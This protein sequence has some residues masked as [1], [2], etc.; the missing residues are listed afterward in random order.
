MM[1]TSTSANGTTSTATGTAHTDSST[2]TNSTSTRTSTST[3][4]STSASTT[5]TPTQPLAP[6]PT[7]SPSCLV[8][9]PSPFD[10]D[11]TVP[12]AIAEQLPPL[13]PGDKLL[14]LVCHEDSGSTATPQPK[15]VGIY[16]VPTHK[17]LTLDPPPDCTR[18]A[19]TVLYE[20][21]RFAQL[22]AGGNPN[23]V[24]VLYTDSGRGHVVHCCRHVDTLIGHRDA[25]VTKSVLARMAALEQQQQAYPDRVAHRQHST[26]RGGG[27]PKPP[28][29]CEE[30]KTTKV[31]PTKWPAV[32]VQTPDFNFLSDWILE[33]RL[34]LQ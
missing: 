14:C 19:S 34:K 5:C 30:T 15:L 9:T 10:P 2:G 3:S 17:L 28:T 18:N 26:K 4:T 29:S 13:S 20:A 7:P 33:I 6:T 12:I 32:P 22:L 25:F 27:A 1:S 31:Q 23:A 11:P 16:A 21:G 24:A 8:A